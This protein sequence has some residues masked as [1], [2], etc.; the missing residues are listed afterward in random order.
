MRILAFDYTQIGIT[1]VV[2]ALL[3]MFLNSTLSIVK[4][5]SGIIMYPQLEIA[6]TARFQATGMNTPDTCNVS[7]NLV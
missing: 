5:H 3:Y 2:S 6:Q 4:I 7:L 1:V